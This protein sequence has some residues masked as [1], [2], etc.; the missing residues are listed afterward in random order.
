MNMENKIGFTIQQPKV[1]GY[2][3]TGGVHFAMFR[4]PNR[5]QRWMHNVFFGW[6]WRDA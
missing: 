5:F 1:V 4:K 3:N 2:W 6:T